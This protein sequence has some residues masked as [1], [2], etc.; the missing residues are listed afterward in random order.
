MMSSSS[1]ANQQDPCKREGIAMSICCSGLDAVCRVHLVTIDVSPTHPLLQ[2]AQVIPWPALAE[3]VLPDLKRTTAKSK[4]WL[5]RKLTVRIHLGAFLLQWLDNLTDRRVEWAIKDNAAY[6]LFCGRGSVNT[7]HCPDHTKIEEF[8]S[9]LSPETQRAVANVI[10]V[11]ATHL[12]FADPSAMDI[13]STV[14]EA[15]IAYPSDAHLM[16]KMT[17]L[18]NKVWTYMKH[19]VS[20]FADFIPCIDVKAVKAKARAYLFR[21][22]QDPTQGQAAFQALWHEA[23]TQISHVKKYFDVLLDYDLQRLPWNIRRSLNQVNEYCSHFF[24]HVASCMCREVIVSEK[25]LSFHAKA[26]S[27]FNKG[28]LAKRWQFGRAFQLGRIGGN[29]VVVGACTSIRMEDKAAVCPMIE[30][31]QGLFGAGVL[32]SFGTDKGYYSGANR[33]CLRSVEGL[34]EFCLQQ[35][36]LDPGSLSERDMITS[37]RLMDRR[38][39][40]EPLISQ[41]KQ[42]GQLGQSR[43]KTDDTTLAAGYGAMGGFNLRQLIRHLLGKDIKPMR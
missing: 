6:Q 28:K 35:P 5:G 1:R 10:A 3:L 38:A 14:Q 31:H 27:C 36:G 7:W 41:A 43:M 11:W 25:A 34:E 15:N 9:R 19:H 24:L 26:V 8:R 30:E 29:F 13:D 20:F 12:G 16:V 18:V 37:R 23:F 4:W 40:I 17:L 39:G 32:R 22:R 33:Q 21:D 42:G 2:L